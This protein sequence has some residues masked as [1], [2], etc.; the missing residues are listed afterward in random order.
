MI[1]SKLHYISQGDAVKD[2][3]EHIQKACSSGAELVQ[4]RLKNVSEKTL[5]KAAEEAR[6]ITAHY[7]TR[8][9]INDH[10]KIAKAVKADGVHLGKTD[11]SPTEAR[12]TLYSWQMIGGTANTLEDCQ[13]LLAQNVDYI[14]LGPYRF[15]TTKNNLSPVLRYNGYLT[16]LETLQTHTPIIAIGGITLDDVSE[17]LT[18]GIHGI[19]VSGEIT[20]NFNSIAAFQKLLNGDIV[21]EQ[22]WKPNKKN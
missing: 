8:L 17:L 10:Y 19:A 5:L 1:V 20:K 22:V 4:L 6:D 11:A 9:I 16:L 12:K 18:T 13:N 2:H 7:Q 15:T 21:H 14:G 3:L